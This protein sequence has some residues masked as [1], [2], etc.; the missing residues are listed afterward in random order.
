[1]TGCFNLEKEAEWEWNIC[2]R[3]RL[4]HDRHASHRGNDRHRRN[5]RREWIRNGMQLFSTGTIGVTLQHLVVSHTFLFVCFYFCNKEALI[6]KVSDKFS[7]ILSMLTL[8]RD[9]K[10]GLCFFFFNWICFLTPCKHR[11]YNC[12]TVESSLLMHPSSLDN[13]HLSTKALLCA[14]ACVHTHECHWLSAT[15]IILLPPLFPFPS[16]SL[17]EMLR[18]RSLE[19]RA[20]FYLLEN[21]FAT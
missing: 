13:L 5:E 21:D 12:I 7:S 18:K 15:A 11:R 4:C 17:W 1:M 2:R 14:C 16:F 10:R 9:L 6:W 3:W 8:M 20:L 19:Y